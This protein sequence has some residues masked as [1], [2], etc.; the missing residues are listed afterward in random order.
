MLTSCFPGAGVGMRMEGKTQNSIHRAFFHVFAGLRNTAL[1][2][3]RD[4]KIHT[5]LPVLRAFLSNILEDVAAGSPCQKR[6]GFSIN[7]TPQRVEYAEGD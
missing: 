2:S 3:V 5:H 1:I 6:Q 4:M 7:S